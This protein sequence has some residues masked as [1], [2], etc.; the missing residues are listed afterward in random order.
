[1]KLDARAVERFLANPG[2]CRV[3]LLHGEDAGLIRERANQLTRK[4][5]GGLDDAF[6]VASLERDTQDRLEEEATA[7]SLV[8]GRRVV[9]VRDAVDALAPQVERALRVRSDNLIVIEAAGLPS[10]SRL[11]S[12]LEGNPEAV[13]IACYQEDGRQL[14]ASLRQ[15]IERE[16]CRIDPDAL[17]FLTEQLGADRAATRSEVEK[18][19]LHAG[20]AGVIDLEMVEACVADASAVS[21]DDAL[22]AATTG[23]LTSMDRAIERAIADGAA[24]VQIVRSLLIHLH[25]L[26]AAR[27]AM[28]RDGLAP[29]AA[30]RTIR[31]PVFFKRQTAFARALGLWSVDLIERAARE[32]NRVE[33]ACKQT[34]APDLALSRHLVWTV[35]GQAAAKARA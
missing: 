25:R 30:M 34:G 22:F 1:M 13:V 32:T 10:R 24:A 35:A 28:E 18:L 4:V 7:L 26:R 20:E 29:D 15:M 14:A 6:R 21:L 19:V 5:A 8:G 16:G 11:R 3:V 9:R 23:D 27:I 31:P 2:D 17:A 33:L 12:A